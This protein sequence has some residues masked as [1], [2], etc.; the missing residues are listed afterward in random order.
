MPG[1]APRCRFSAQRSLTAAAET[2]ISMPYSNFW[3]RRNTVQ[4]ARARS[5]R[6]ENR[7]TA[8]ARLDALRAT[9]GP[10]FRGIWGMPGSGSSGSARTCRGSRRSGRAVPPALACSRRRC[11]KVPSSARASSGGRIEKCIGDRT[12]GRRPPTRRPPLAGE[13]G[14]QPRLGLLPSK[15]PSVVWHSSVRSWSRS[16]SVRWV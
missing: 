3:L 5:R 15:R 13:R 11:P 2:C 1:S 6:R 4:T 10:G 9:A 14:D 12:G 7:R 16:G 8:T